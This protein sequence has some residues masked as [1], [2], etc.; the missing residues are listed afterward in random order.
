MMSRREALSNNLSVI[1]PITETPLLD[2]QLIMCHVLKI[3][4]LKLILNQNQSLSEVDYTEYMKLVDERAVGRPVQYIISEQEF[5]GL[6]FYVDERV[7]IPRGD[8]EVLVEA[9]VEIYKNKSCKFVEVGTGS[10]AIAVSLVKLL[11]KSYGI[12]LDI[13]EDALDVARKN[14][15]KNGVMDRLELLKSDV[16]DGLNIDEKSLDFIVSNPPYIPTEVLDKLH[17]RVKD[18][19]PHMALDGGDDG[20]DFYRQIVD[21]SRIYLR[22]GGQVFFEVGHDQSGDISKLFV[23]N[24]YRDIYTIKDLQGFERVVIATF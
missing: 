4:R 8:T 10:G 5:M 6:D 15:K 7:L 11:D 23:E 17:V 22:D 3:D 14:A 24:G 2:L 19:E 16:F 1:E 12:T 18:F 13:S 20:L 21:K 9:I